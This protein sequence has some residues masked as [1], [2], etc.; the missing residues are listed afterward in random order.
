MNT[1]A[2]NRKGSG[3]TFSG[4]TQASLIIMAF[5]VC[6]SATIN[7]S[8][9]Q[10]LQITD[11]V[12]FAGDGTN[13]Q[14]LAVPP[15]PGYGVS[16]GTSNT[17]SGGNI[18]S[19]VLVKTSGNIT[20]NVRSGQRVEFSNSI[21]M[22]GSIFAANSNASTGTTVL[23]GS[24][25]SLTGSI[26]ANGNI[27]VGG[28]SISGSVTK[29]SNFTY[30]GPTPT[31]GVI[32]AVPVIPALPSLPTPTI[33]PPAGTQNITA[34]TTITPGAYGN[35]TLGGNRTITLSGPGDYIFNSI[36]NS[37][38]SNIFRF[39]FQNNP[40]GVF[41][42]FVKGNAFLNKSTATIL[43][44]GS[45]NR[46]YMEVQGNGAGSTSN[47][48]SFV[49]ANGASGGVSRWF[50]T[51]YAPFAGIFM[52]SGTGSTSI[53]GSLWSG[54]QVLINS[55]VT[56][57]YAAYVNCQT[58]VANAGPDR[59]IDCT[60]ATVTLNGSSNIAGSTF[61]WVASNG[62]NIVSGA[63]TATPVVNAAGTYTLTVTTGSACSSTDV[64]LVTTNLTAPNVNAGVDK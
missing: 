50:G 6:F 40:N 21:V 24:S 12:L 10:N 9:A 55:G 62:G 4:L 32:N 52:G 18:G 46:I 26:L 51:V 41:R 27:S 8:E 36:N 47:A 1:S 43:N 34:N 37:G 57:N 53:T 30:T 15:A 56:T 5:F 35:V 44:G 2:P 60:N 28:G 25:L 17:V 19:R 33:I 20:G 7:K 38:T 49:I 29:P 31:G 22:N 23:T 11:F 64:A 54:T 59:T 45:A 63:N 14:G 3:F 58:P 16:I 48:Y 39:D 42:I 61:S 13:P